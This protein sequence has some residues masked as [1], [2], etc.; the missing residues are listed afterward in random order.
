MTDRMNETLIRPRLWLGSWED[1]DRCLQNK[2]YEVITVAWES[3][4][5]GHHSYPLTD[6][7]SGADEPG[8]LAAAADKA[9]H[10]LQN[11]NK[12]VLIHCYSG[13]NRST[14]VVIAVLMKFDGLT[15]LEAYNQVIAVR[16]FVWPFPRHL[17][18]ALKYVGSNEIVDVN[19]LPNYG[20]DR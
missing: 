2:Q 15:L 14:C 11:T 20:G 19:K 8:L 18:A 10:L 3:P 16:P 17:Q 13:I 12:E 9:I 6:P 7:G 1:A 4:I 5:E